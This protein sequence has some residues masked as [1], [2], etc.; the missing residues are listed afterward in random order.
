MQS[1]AIQKFPFGVR[2][3][4][5][6]LC[7]LLYVTIVVIVVVVMMIGKASGEKEENLGVTC[8]IHYCGICKMSI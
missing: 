1:A 2:K 8:R 7:S 3:L 4:S 5:N 6:D